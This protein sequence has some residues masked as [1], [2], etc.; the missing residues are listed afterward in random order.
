[1]FEKV[2]VKQGSATPFYDRLA[3]QAGGEYPGWNFHKYLIDRSG[4]VV[5]SFGS[6]VKPDDESLLAAIEQSLATS[7]KPAPETP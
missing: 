6:R 7:L 1:M 3:A 5:R 4:K 2:S